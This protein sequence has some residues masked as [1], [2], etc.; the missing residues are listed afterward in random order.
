[1]SAGS[2]N[3]VV[4]ISAEDLE[5]PEATLELLS[6]PDALRRLNQAQADVAAGRRVP[7]TEMAAEME[8]RR[9]REPEGCLRDRRG[10]DGEHGSR[11]AP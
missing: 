5:S 6:D 7:E 1:M 4:L 9:Q 3:Y 11:P 10:G 2:L 8:Q